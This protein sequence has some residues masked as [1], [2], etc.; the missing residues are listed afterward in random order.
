MSL[1]RDSTTLAIRRANVGCVNVTPAAAA[2]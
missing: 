1:T 2:S